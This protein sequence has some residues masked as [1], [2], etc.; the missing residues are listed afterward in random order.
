VSIHIEKSSAQTEA[1]SNADDSTG[2]ADGSGSRY[3]VVA[4]A[5]PAGL[6]AAYEMTKHGLDGIVF[7]KDTVVGGIARTVDI[8]GWRFDIGGHRFFTK[9]REVEDL[10]HEMM[11]S[12][13][14]TRPRLSRIYYKGR[15]YYYPLRAFNALSNL[16]IFEAFRC[17]LSY[18]KA[19]MFPRPK[20]ESFEDYIVNKFGERLYKHFFKTYTEKVWGVPCTE[21]RA[22]WAAQRIK[23]LSLTSAIVNA[24]FKP[25]KQGIKTLIERF[26]YPRLGP[27]MMWEKFTEYV[28]AHGIEVRMGTEVEKVKW[29][30]RRIT[31]AVL[32]PSIGEPYSVEATDFISSMPIRELIAKMDP[33]PPEEVRRAAEGLRYRDFLTVALVID[34]EHLFDDNWIY[35]HS[36]DV[37]LGRIQNFK[38]WSPEMVP[39]QSKT[40]LG[41]E[42]FAFE[43]DDLWTMSDDALVKLGEEE[44][45]KLGLIRPGTVERG[46]VVRM[47]KAYPMYDSNYEDRIETLREFLDSVEGLH[48]VGR[49]GMHKYN[50][51]D[52]SMLT[53]MLAVRNIAGGSY[54]VWGVNVEQ[55]Y[56]EEGEEVSVSEGTESV[57]TASGGS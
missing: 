50:N 22:E 18:M 19:R 47:P 29:D 16:G 8:E 27:G 42:Y 28:Q 37:K 30:G 4:G 14:I 34:E 55:E 38:N 9:V 7:E 13:F 21:I 5:G 32:R 31:G 35:I 56:H 3:V 23:G 48:P 26:E 51:Q 53:A 40:C 36:P 46:W 54:D 45:L 33:P 11:G 52:H 1:G 39:E 20:E 17:V 49:N 43:G 15:F 6:T 41:L 57:I 12:D 24:V 10:W 44:L 2:P 25:K